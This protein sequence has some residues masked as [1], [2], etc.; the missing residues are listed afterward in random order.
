MNR[1]TI[2]HMLK[3]PH[4]EPPGKGRFDIRRWLQLNDELG[5]YAEQIEILRSG[6]ACDRLAIYYCPGWHLSEDEERLGL[7]ISQGE[8]YFEIPVHEIWEMGEGIVVLSHER[9]PWR[10]SGWV[11]A[12]HIPVTEEEAVWPEI[13]FPREH[14]A[15]RPSPSRFVRESA[16]GE[17]QEYL[18][19]SLDG[20]PGSHQLDGPPK[21]W[22]RLGLL[23]A[24][25]KQTW[26]WDLFLVNSPVVPCW[27]EALLGRLQ[28]V[29]APYFYDFVTEYVLEGRLT[30][31][32]SP[33]RLGAETLRVPARS[34]FEAM[35]VAGEKL[36]LPPIWWFDSV[37]G[38]LDLS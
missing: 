1:K 20:D 7:W 17:E 36:R 27:A 14:W 16:D 21:R 5:L 2:F 38:R 35:S 31:M 6:P 10:M 19:L 15:E 9:G 26:V 34:L 29:D 3:G 4:E 28:Q 24:S 11:I 18:L 8:R 33:Y 13:T 22:D 25:P 32:Y 37:R 23:I 12:P 30:N